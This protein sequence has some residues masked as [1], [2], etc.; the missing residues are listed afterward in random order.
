MDAFISKFNGKNINSYKGDW[1]RR[2]KMSVKEIGFK[3]VAFDDLVYSK[4]S[5]SGNY[6]LSFDEK[7][8]VLGILDAIAKNDKWTLSTGTV[9]EDKMRE[10]VVSSSFEH[11]VHSLIIDPF[12]PIWKKHFT[13]AEL[14]E[15]NLF[16]AKN[17]EDLSDDVHSYLN[18]Y[19][20]EWESAIDLYCFAN[21]QKH[22]PIKEF[23][24]GWIKENDLLHSVWRFVY[25]AFSRGQIKAMLGES[26]SVAVAMSRNK[27]RAL[28]VSERRPRKSI[29][30]KLDV[31]FKAG[32]HELG[33][34]EAGKSNIVPADDKYLDD[35]LMKLPKTLRDMLAMLVTANPEKVNSLVTVGFLMMGLEME[36]VLMDV[37]VGHSIS[38]ISKSPKLQF[39]LSK[40]NIATD[41]ISLIEITWKGK[42]MMEHIVRMLNDRKRKAA[43]MMLLTDVDNEAI[44]S[45]SFVRNK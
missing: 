44:L 2:I 36:V 17:L 1:K 22:H 28:E 20:Q 26:C 15:I 11:P 3:L 9:V 35:G 13:T 10:L 37:P 31:L 33:S 16:K 24:R 21:N 40:S 4:T 41:F 23:E 45:F 18:L 12:D 30:A 42:R 27:D 39:P 14:S 8:R 29:G 34:C 25:R 43:A 19:D 38:R 5:K 7:K 32:V 6:I